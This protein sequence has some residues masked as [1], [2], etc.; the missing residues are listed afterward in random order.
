LILSARSVH[1]KN[2][3]HIMLFGNV[4]WLETFGRWFLAVC[5]KYRIR[6]GV[7]Q[8]LCNGSS[9]NSPGMRW[10]SGPS[11]LGPFGML[12]IDLFTRTVN[13]LRKSPEQML[14]LFFLTTIEQRRP[15]S[16][17]AQGCLSQASCLLSCVSFVLYVIQF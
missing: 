14:R 8:C 13:C 11:L 4:P 10:K 12:E 6:E 2:K 1:R 16:S 17:N 15:P 9:N 3:P 5:K 7:F